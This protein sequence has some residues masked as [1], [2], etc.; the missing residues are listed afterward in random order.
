ME[1]WAL[2]NSQT[3]K[4]HLKDELGPLW[5]LLGNSLRGRN[6]VLVSKVMESCRS[7]G[8]AGRGWQV[9]GQASSPVWGWESS[10]RKGCRC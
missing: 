1:N 3:L 10:H 6:L 2:K 4:R 7:R 9:E 5:G 8:L